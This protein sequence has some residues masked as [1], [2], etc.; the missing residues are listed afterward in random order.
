[1]SKGITDKVAVIGMGCTRFAEHWDKSA[2]DLL[3]EAAYE[4]FADAGVEPSDIDACWLGT[5]ASGLSGLTLSGP[6]KTQYIPVTRVENMCATGSEAFRNACY[7]VASGAYDM[8]L[9][10][11][12]EK[13]KDSGYSGL[14]VAEPPNDGTTPPITAPAAF[15]FLAPAYFS[16]YGLDP[17]KGK[18]VLTRIAWKNHRNGSLNPKAQFRSEVPLEAIA[19]SPMVAAPLGIMD[20]SGV[21]DGAAAAIIVRTEDAPKYRKDPMYVKALTIAA[22]PGDGVLRQDFDFTSIR[23]NVMAAKEAYRQAGITDPRKQIDMAEVHDCFTPTELVIYEDL[24][25]SERGKAWQDV[26]NGVFD[27][28]GELPVNPDGGLKSFGHPIGASGLRML[29]EM[30]LQFQGKAGKRQLPN[31]KI[32][33]THNLGGFPWQCVSFISIVG[34]ELG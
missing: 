8:A 3:V 18:E 13:L 23:E 7:A 24:G 15:S 28:E 4:A 20:C 22:G 9:A 19:K 11:G 32:G 1:M 12:V 26:L 25:F 34:K 14:A 16:K 33:L 5:F 17:E 21:A 31:P 2:D 29:Y 6:L 30:Y 27:L 10:I